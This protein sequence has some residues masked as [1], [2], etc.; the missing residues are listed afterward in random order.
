MRDLATR[1]FRYTGCSFFKSIF[2][3]MH[4]CGHGIIGIADHGGRCCT[5][6]GRMYGVCQKNGTPYPYV[7]KGII[8]ETH[9]SLGLASQ[10]S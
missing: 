5:I 4:T 8:K 9:M 10:Q 3:L 7:L 1:A 2:Y 6:G